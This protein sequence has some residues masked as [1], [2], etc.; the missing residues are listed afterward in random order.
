[1][2]GQERAAADTLGDARG[3]EGI[4]WLPHAEG[5]FSGIQ[6]EGCSIDIDPGVGRDVELVLPCRAGDGGP[7]CSGCQECAQAADH[8]IE[9]VLPGV[10]DIAGP[11]DLGQLFMRDRPRVM[12]GEIGEGA[13]GLAA[14][15]LPLVERENLVEREAHPAGQVEADYGPSPIKK[16]GTCAKVLPRSGQ[17]MA[18][19]MRPLWLR[20]R[21]HG[22]GH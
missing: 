21:S 9:S 17:S 22:E 15:H 2:A 3:P 20:R 19:I 18:R 1:M 13:S 6:G 11:E 12:G 7:R 14:P 16:E 10:R 4:A 8:G 5:S